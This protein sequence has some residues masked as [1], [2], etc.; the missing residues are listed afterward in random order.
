M[1]DWADRRDIRHADVEAIRER[2]AEKQ[3][4]AFMQRRHVEAL[5]KIAASLE[6]LPGCVSNT[7]WLRVSP[8]LPYKE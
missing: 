2:E 6:K 5:E 3:E 1:T 4:A 7:G 8:D